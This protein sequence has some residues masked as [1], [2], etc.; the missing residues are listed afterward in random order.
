M[1]DALIDELRGLLNY[2][3]DAYSPF[4]L[5]L[6]GVPA[7]ARRLSMAQHKATFSRIQL[8]YELRGFSETDTLKY[9]EHQMAYA[10][11]IS[12]IFTDQAKQK[13]HQATNGNP[14]LINKMANLCLLTAA[15]AEFKLIDD[16][17]VIQV[18]E[19]EMAGVIA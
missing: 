8:Q 5:V 19:T 2:E 9:I 17:L 10:G 3:C 18:L 11:A 1:P 12:Q 6:C 7:I 4:A 13:I 14:R 16:S 15:T